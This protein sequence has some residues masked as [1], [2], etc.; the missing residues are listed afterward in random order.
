[1]RQSVHSYGALTA[2][3]SRWRRAFPV[4]SGRL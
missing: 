4:T 3:G 2:V 1:V